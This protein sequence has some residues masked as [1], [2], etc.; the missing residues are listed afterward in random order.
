VIRFY[1]DVN[2]LITADTGSALWK[3]GV[4]S[5]DAMGNI[6]TMRLDEID[7]G[8]GDGLSSDPKKNVPPDRPRSARRRDRLT[9]LLNGARGRSMSF[10]YDGTTS[11]L[12]SVTLNDGLRTVAHDPAGNQ[13]S[14][15]VLRSYS[16][17]NYLHEVRDESE[18]G[19]LLQHTVRYGYDGRGVRVTRTETP[20]NGANTSARRYYFYSPELRLLAQTRDDAPNVWEPAPPPSGLAD[21]NIQYEIVWFADRPVAELAPAAP[22]LSTFADHLGTPI[23]QTDPSR[24]VTWR[25]EYE[26]FGNVYEMR[27]GVRTDQPLRFPG[28]E[29]A[30]TWEGPEERYN[31]FRWYASGWGRYTQSDPLDELRASEPNLY[32]YARARPTRSTDPLGLWAVDDSCSNCPFGGQLKVQEGVD[33]ACNKFLKKPKCASFIENLTF[34]RTMDGRTQEALGPC[35]R[36]LCQGDKKIYCAINTDRQ[37]PRACAK[38]NPGGALTLMR[39]AGTQDCYFDQGGGWSHTI[40]HEMVHVCG[41]TDERSESYGT[42]PYSALFRKI[43]WTCA[44]VPY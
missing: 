14:Y 13:T 1:D 19:D 7:P 2:R 15:A 9:T 20:S 21:K 5:W 37:Q 25:A 29:V 16:A 38:A 34:G 23:L 4:F 10:G 41:L 43:M 35:M 39:G 26:P 27:A 30:S 31:V 11:V 17:R 8:E 36:R 22:P 6:L 24:T 12:S 28:Q 33:I 18:P 32:L 40:F 44:G 3:K 42:G